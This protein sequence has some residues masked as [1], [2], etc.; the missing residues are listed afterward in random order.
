MVERAQN[1][2]IIN[3]KIEELV[4]YENNPR[5]NDTAVKYVAESIRS[6][7]FKIPMVIDSENVIVCG[8][9]RYKAAKELGMTEVPCIV[10]DDLTEEQIKAFRL[11]DNKVGEI[12]TWDMEALNAELEE[13]ELDMSGFGFV[14]VSDIDID[15]FFED[16]E[17]KATE[18]EEPKEIKCPHCGLYFTVD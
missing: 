10:A 18:D 12:A 9:T 1:M 2:Q 8:H 16:A 3:R 5:N 7:G 11:A 4:P 13:L 14:E 17:P 15:N 6:F